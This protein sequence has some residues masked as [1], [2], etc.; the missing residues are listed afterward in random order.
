MGFSREPPVI[1]EAVP[2][3]FQILQPASPARV[4]GRAGRHPT[5]G[6]LRPSLLILVLR[7]EWISGKKL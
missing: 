3:R 6:L 4:T 5:R 2:D 1:V 7:N